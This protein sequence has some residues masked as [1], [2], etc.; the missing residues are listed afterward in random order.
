MPIYHYKC[1]K[2]ECSHEFEI[3]HSIKKKALRKCPVCAK[4]SLERILY[5]AYGRVSRRADQ[6]GTVGDLAKFNTDKLTKGEKEAKDHD[7][8]SS[9]RLAKEK[10]KKQ[11]AEKPWYHSSY[12]PKDLTTRLGKATDKQKKDYLNKGIIPD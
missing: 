1:S 5:P 3:S 12:E 6:M 11:T 4:L 2:I 9:S 7:Y 10:L 8:E